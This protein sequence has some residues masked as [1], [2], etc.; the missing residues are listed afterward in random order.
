MKNFYNSWKNKTEFEK[1]GIKTLELSK[2]LILER[3]PKKEI[4]SIYIKGSFMRREMDKNSDVDMV[5]ILKTTKHFSKIKK[6]D[7]WGKKCGLKPYP[8]FIAYS[9]WELKTGK[10]VKK[11]VANNHPSRIVKH[12]GEYKLIYGE[13]LTGEDFFM[14]SDK[15]DLEKMVEVFTENWI[16]LYKEDKFDF[17]MILKQTFWLVENAERASGRN[18]PHSWKKLKDSIEDKNHIIYDAWNLRESRIKDK[19]IR[20]EYIKKLK[21]YLGELK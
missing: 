3:V 8:Q 10:R 4:V 1:S 14:R 19:K 12:L 11:K 13:D 15:E 2:K 16:P 20:S 17:N 9:I 6:L 5:V 18:P 7:N 21:G